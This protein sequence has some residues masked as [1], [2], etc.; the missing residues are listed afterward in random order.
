[1]L[2]EDEIHNVK[3]GHMKKKTRKGKERKL[4]KNYR[5]SLMGSHNESPGGQT[6]P[7]MEDIQRRADTIT[8]VLKEILDFRP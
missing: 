1:M 3:G 8:P 4:I 5:V 7:Y 6:P 2:G